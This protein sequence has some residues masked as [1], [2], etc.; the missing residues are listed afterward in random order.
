MN[1][2]KFCLG[3]EVEDGGTPVAGGAHWPGTDWD[4]CW[5]TTSRYY[6]FNYKLPVLLHMIIIIEVDVCTWFAIIVRI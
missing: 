4:N 5:D 2:M 6:R 1:E 3:L